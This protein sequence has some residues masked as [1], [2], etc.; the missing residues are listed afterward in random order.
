MNAWILW[1]EL[2]PTNILS[3]EQMSDLIDNGFEHLAVNDT[4]S[5]CDTLLKV[6]EA[7][8]YRIKP[9]FK[10]L[11]YLDKQNKGSFFIRNFC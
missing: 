3:M 8:K 11:D 6:W 5:A 10:N 9:S 1:E 4:I 2:A 7:L